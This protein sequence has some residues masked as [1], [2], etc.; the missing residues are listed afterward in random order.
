[1]DKETFFFYDLETSGLSPRDDRIMQFAGIRTELDL[2]PIGEPVNL[3][4]QLSEDTLPSPDALMVTKITPQQT[5]LDGL[6]EPEFCKYVSEEIFTPGTIAVGYNSVRFDD[7]FMR[8]TFW[9]NFYDPYE[10]QWKD[11]RS[12]WDLLDVVRMTR[13]LRPEGIK[14]PFQPA[15]KF[16]RETGAREEVLDDDGKPVM[17]ATNRLELITELNG[18]KHEHAHDALS[19]VEALI[20]VTRLIRERQPKLYEYLLAMR[21]KKRVASLV[22]LKKPAPF[23]YSC[24]E[25]PSAYEKTSVAYPLCPGRTPNSVLVYD[26]RYDPDEVMEREKIFPVVKELCL[27][28]CPAVAPLGVL[29]SD[30]TWSRIGLTKDTVEKNLEKLLKHPEIAKVAVETPEP[31]FAEPVDAEAA[32]YDG[33]LSDSDRTRVEAVRNTG[34]SKLAGFSPNFQDK[35]LPEL[36]LH[37]KG[38]NFPNTLSEAEAAAFADYRNARL[39][40]QAVGFMKALERLQAS[41][42]A[43]EFILEEL[44]LWFQGLQG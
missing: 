31:D 25:Y 42:D 15:K 27:N 8:H 44:G 26:L 22:D 29:N 37:Y 21:D 24:G 39:N 28:K 20:S 40:R 6:S 4:V 10:W 43:D 12:R 38:R 19:D 32:L 33:F 7:E 41:G 2:N 16:N 35:R 18:I 13:A 14:W 1:M 3:L 9:R 5:R 11:G 23:V 36:L 17:V 34:P 30:E